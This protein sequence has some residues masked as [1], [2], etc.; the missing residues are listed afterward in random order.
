MAELNSRSAGGTSSLQIFV[1]IDDYLTMYDEIL[2]ET[3]DFLEELAKEGGAYGIFF[4]VAG[5]RQ[6]LTRFCNLSV[7]AFVNCLAYKNAIALSE[8]LKEYSMF[9]SMHGEADISIGAREGVLL[10]DGKAVFLKI[11][12]V[13]EAVRNA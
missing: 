4:Y 10:S 8:R 6:E 12:N 3:A 13:K 1:L 9:G 5:D 2:D 7:P 11:A